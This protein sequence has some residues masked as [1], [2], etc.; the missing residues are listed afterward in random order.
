M[1]LDKHLA[2][3]VRFLAEMVEADLDGDQLAGRLLRSADYRVQLN[4]IINRLREND[5]HL[6]N[7]EEPS[8]L[9]GLIVRQGACEAKS[10]LKYIRQ[11]LGGAVRVTFCDPYFL[12]Y[13]LSS[14]FEDEGKYVNAIL[15]LIPS[16]AK[17]VDIFC[18]G[19]KRT[20]RAEFLRSAR[21]GRMVR[22]YSAGKMH[23]RFVIRD[24]EIKL[25]GTSFGGFGNKIFSVIDLL[26]ADAQ[27][28]RDELNLIRR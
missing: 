13:R 28:V 19:F 17:Q 12:K 7:G 10:S 2:T 27:T 6:S 18:D 4:R 9:L 25:V 16:T 22:V 5:G 11:W 3:Q 14:Y 8:E 26:P 1:D 23:D 15:R 24:N 21:N 20:T